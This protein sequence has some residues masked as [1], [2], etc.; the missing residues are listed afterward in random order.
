[1]ALGCWSNSTVEHLTTRASC[2]SRLSFLP[3]R[4]DRKE[5][6][7]EEVASIHHD[8]INKNSIITIISTIFHKKEEKIQDKII[9]LLGNCESESKAIKDDRCDKDNQQQKVQRLL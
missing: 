4:K 8:G 6:S 7:L 9:L 5:A 2:S 3:H 1:M